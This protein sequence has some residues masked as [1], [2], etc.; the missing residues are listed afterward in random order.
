MSRQ[1]LP[2][3]ILLLFGMAICVLL[4]LRVARTQDDADVADVQE[5]VKTFIANISHHEAEKNLAVFVRHDTAVVGIS[6]GEGRGRIWQKSAEDWLN[7]LQAAPAGSPLVVDSVDVDFI[8]TALAVARVKY[9]GGTINLRA[10]F[11]VS[12]EGGTGRIVSLVFE[13]RAR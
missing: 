1:W 4:P 7:E 2:S 8:D 3:R 12:S 6:G 10:V 9:H 13:T 5:L 11:T